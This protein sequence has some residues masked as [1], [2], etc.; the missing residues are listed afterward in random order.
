MMPIQIPRQQSPPI[1]VD[2]SHQPEVEVQQKE[3][4]KAYGKAQEAAEVKVLLK[5]SERD[6]NDLPQNEESPEQRGKN[7]PF[8]A[9]DDGVSAAPEPGGHTQPHQRVEGEGDGASAQFNGPVPGA[10][11]VAKHAP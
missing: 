7:L 2:G 4:A 3:G 1:I 5:G 11:A 9:G 10:Q 6:R 8:F